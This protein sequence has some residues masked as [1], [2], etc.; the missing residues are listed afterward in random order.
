MPASQKTL[1]I[2]RRS[3]EQFFARHEV[4]YYWTFTFGEVVGDKGEANRRWK[5]FVDLVKR[6]GGDHLEF[7]ELQE[8]GSWHVHCVTDLYFDVKWLRP[9]LVKRGWG[10]QMV[11]KRV[12][13]RR[14]WKDGAGWV[15][16]EREEERL[17]RYLMKYLTKCLCVA[18]TFKTKAF[19][20]SARAKIGTTVFKWLPEIK[21]GA[22][23]YYYGRQVFFDMFGAYP[24]LRDMGCVLRLGYEST[25]WCD[26]DPLLDYG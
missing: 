7:W 9:W 14:V 26:V 18:A 1:Y 4:V 23:L 24:K 25:G 16:D 22:Y 5:P 10:P 3:L 11:A 21:P 13:S 15:R 12:G 19:G 20:S 2:A 8:R 17:V 6:R